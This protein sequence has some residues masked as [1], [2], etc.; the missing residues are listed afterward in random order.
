MKFTITFSTVTTGTMTED[1][2]CDADGDGVV[3]IDLS[4]RKDA[5]ALGTQN[6]LDYTVTYHSSQIDADA[7]TPFLPNPYPANDGD[8]IFVRVQNIATGC[9][10]SNSNFD[11]YLIGQQLR[12]RH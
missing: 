7:G 10:V 5:E 12:L 2:I 4:F 9:F 11:S 8:Q 6:P 3:E 1:R